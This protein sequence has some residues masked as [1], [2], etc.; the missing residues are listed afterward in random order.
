MKF[1]EINNQPPPF[2]SIGL[3]EPRDLAEAADVSA[4]G[5]DAW[6]KDAIHA[7]L[8][9]QYNNGAARLFV[10]RQVER[11]PREP[12]EPAIAARAFFPAP[13]FESRA[14]KMVGFAA[15]QLVCDEASLD[16]LTVIPAFRRQGVAHCLLRCAFDHLTHQG[17]NCCFLEVRESNAPA[18]ALYEGLGFAAVGR[19][20]GF[21]RAPAE[22]A[23]VMRCELPNPRP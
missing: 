1:I 3:M 23:V 18:I 20:P 4:T 21:Y 11:F 12:V 5:P 8:W 10:A 19:R 2:F 7:G 15:F 13:V 22:D 9:E 16:A 17:A 14:T 6:S